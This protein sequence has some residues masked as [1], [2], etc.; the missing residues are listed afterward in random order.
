MHPLKKSIGQAQNRHPVQWQLGSNYVHA[1]DQERGVIPE[2]PAQSTV[3]EQNGTAKG[4]GLR[5]GG[6]HQEDKI[7]ARSL[8][9]T[10]STLRVRVHMPEEVEEAI[11][12]EE[13][14]EASA[15]PSPR[16]WT[17]C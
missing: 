6:Q 16:T 9:P 7:A 14:R 1:L 13:E 12:S 15:N 10:L 17:R 4:D 8:W 3:H 5:G 2:A 11:A